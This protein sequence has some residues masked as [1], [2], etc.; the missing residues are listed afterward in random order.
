[1]ADFA[2]ALSDKHVDFI[3]QQKMFF[4]ATAPAQGEGFPNLSPKGYDAMHILGPNRLVYVD[5]PG[6]G[7][8]TASHLGQGARVTFMFC[9]FENQAWIL[10][11]YGRGR[12][13]LAGT[14]EFAEF[15]AQIDSSVL[16]AATRQIFDIE[17]EKVQTSC[18]WGVP[19]YDFA[20]DR[21]TL[22]K[23]FD[24]AAEKGELSETVELTSAVQE[25][26]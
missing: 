15:A 5:L 12:A 16:G 22:V 10:R 18:G 9:G 19:R 20:G 23:Y 3:R 13:V 2:N 25:N 8:Q 4:V 7:N 6:S 14:P 17:I 24:K 1:M 21:P 26:V 11:V